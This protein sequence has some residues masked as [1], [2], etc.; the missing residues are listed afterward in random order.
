MPQVCPTPAPVRGLP[1]I[2]HDG[3]TSA[4]SFLSHDRHAPRAPA[5]CPSPPA[6]PVIIHPVIGSRFT[7]AP[8][9]PVHC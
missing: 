5:A 2:L 4:N 8:T 3:S 1:Y 7:V 6:Q 9:Y